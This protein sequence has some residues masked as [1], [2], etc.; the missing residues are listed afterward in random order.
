VKDVN[1][2]VTVKV[3]IKRETAIMQK[4]TRAEL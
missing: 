2:K 4:R 1:A 3:C